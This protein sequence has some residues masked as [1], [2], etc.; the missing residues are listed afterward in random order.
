MTLSAQPAAG[1]RTP[2][3][4][5]A[6]IVATPVPAAR[7]AAATA[8]GPADA[9]AAR[10]AALY[11]HA[12]LDTSPEPAF[13]ALTRLARQLFG[14]PMA[15]VALRDAHR[16]WVKSGAGLGLPDAALELARGA[17]A[18]HRLLPPAADV[19]VI[20]DLRCEPRLADNPLLARPDPVR[21]YAAAPIVDE[22]GHALGAVAVLDTQ[23]RSFTPVQRSLLQ[24]LALAA[25]TALQA[26]QRA[27]HLRELA[28]R[29]PLTGAADPQQFAQLLDV[30]MA[31]AM[32]TG[33]PFAVLRLDLDGFGDIN[34]AYGQAAGD[35]VLREVGRR[36]HEQVRQGD[37]LARL[38]SDDFGIVMRHGGETEARML[39]SRIVAAV[40]QPVALG[41]GG[42]AVSPGISV[43]LAA[44]ADDVVSVGELLSR[45]DA[46]LQ[47]DRA[48]KE[49]RWMVFGK[50]FEGGPA[51]A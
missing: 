26:R 29:D 4:A 8:A 32:R 51:L 30:E 48:H 9:E 12:I 6:D 39:A 14:M 37:L 16:L 28:Q 43:G 5:T 27:R 45:A 18:L 7:D 23:A 11:A 36:L 1:G 42:E 33:E 15:W 38:G 20:E 41:S 44:Y 34:T 21:F 49:S 24:D 40:R 25:L 3:P 13:D 17:F 22:D 46:S 35:A 19:V 10:L 47:R 2:S 31:H 50:L